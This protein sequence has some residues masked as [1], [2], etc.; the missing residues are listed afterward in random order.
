MEIVVPLKRRGVHWGRIFFYNAASM[1]TTQTS[2]PAKHINK[3][4]CRSGIP[5]SRHLWGMSVQ[6]DLATVRALPQRSHRVAVW[7][8]SP[9]P[10]KW[11]C[12]AISVHI[13][14]QSRKLHFS[15]GGGWRTTLEGGVWPPWLQWHRNQLWDRNWF[16][17]YRRR[18]W[19]VPDPRPLWSYL[20]YKTHTLHHMS[21]RINRAREEKC[22]LAILDCTCIISRTNSA[23]I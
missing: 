7:P 8:Y 9:E 4:C 5:A 19:K 17:K 18:V 22:E 6:S 15:V 13:P 10:N 12:Q 1:K 16:W 2:W 11:W 23:W 20:L 3:Q 21:I 14:L